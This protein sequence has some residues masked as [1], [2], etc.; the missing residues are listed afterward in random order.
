MNLTAYM[1]LRGKLRPTFGVVCGLRMMV[2]LNQRVRGVETK[3][4]VRETEEGLG[5]N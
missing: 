3:E 1:Q 4:L 2:R 5:G